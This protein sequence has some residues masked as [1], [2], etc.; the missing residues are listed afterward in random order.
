VAAYLERACI[1]S[2]HKIA[3]AAGYCRG[4]VKN[5]L[6]IKHVSR[7]ALAKGSLAAKC[8]ARRASIGKRRGGRRREN[9]IGN[10]SQERA[11]IAGK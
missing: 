5:I 7:T 2:S 3:V 11:V 8:W 4:G 10:A 6:G 9:S 1:A